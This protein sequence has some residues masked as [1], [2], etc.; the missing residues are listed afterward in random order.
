MEDK[1]GNSHITFLVED[2]I[3]LKISLV[4]AI[5]KERPDLLTHLKVTTTTPKDSKEDKK[6]KDVNSEEKSKEKGKQKRSAK[7]K[8][9]TLETTQEKRKATRGK[10]QKKGKEEN[11]ER[12]EEAILRMSGESEDD[13]L[14][15]IGEP[16]MATFLNQDGTD[17]TGWYI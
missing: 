13:E 1:Q 12:E 5:K 11:E 4:A 14:E 16:V 2:W 10:K 8:K 9:E 15:E 7:E 3:F 17:P 6:G